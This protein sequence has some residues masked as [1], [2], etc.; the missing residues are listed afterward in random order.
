MLR[1]ILIVF[2][3]VGMG[4]VLD[5]LLVSI[6]FQLPE[7]A[8]C[9]ITGMLLINLGPKVLP[10][11]DWPL[12]NTSKSLSLMSELSVSLVLVMSLMPMKWS[13]LMG[14][15]PAILLILVARSVL[16]VLIAMV[17]VFRAMGSN[18]DGAVIATGYVGVFLV[19]RQPVW[20]MSL[21]LL[22]AT[23]HLRRRY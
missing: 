15:G 2:I 5:K 10:M 18:Y 21:P 3:A 22:K 19:F 7:F 23:V 12:P 6:N 4:L 1:T 14:A 20:R 8:A 17:V 16:V 13:V 9:M 11:V